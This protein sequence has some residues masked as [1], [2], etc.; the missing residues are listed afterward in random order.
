VRTSFHL[1][2]YLSVSV[3]NLLPN[4]LVIAFGHKSGHGKDSCARAIAERY[5][6]TLDIKRYAF[7]DALKTELYSVLMSPLDSYWETVRDVNYLALPHPR[8]VFCSDEDK[9]EWV[10]GNKKALGS[11]LQR[12]GTEYRRARDSFYW[13]NALRGR[14]Y[15]DQPKVAL[16]T[17]LRFPNEVQFVQACKGYTVKCV[18]DGFVNP[19]RPADHPSETALDTL[20]YDYE[21]HA[22][23]HGIAQLRQD[24]CDLFQ[25][26]L[27]REQPEIPEI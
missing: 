14:I 2:H 4:T 5:G 20:V 23:T 24:A 13:I 11:L 26:I 9:I 15:R 21:I 8:V 12:Y 10:E 3:N 7:A 16:I 27:D 6:D 18:R 17:D 22:T 25:I 19:E 1:V